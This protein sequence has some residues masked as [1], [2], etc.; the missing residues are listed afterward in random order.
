MLHQ[1]LRTAIRGLRHRPGAAVAAL[2]TLTLGIGATT[3][4][5]GVVDH[6]LLRPLA[7]GDAGDLY[8]V[9]GVTAS[10][11]RIQPSH[12]D[13]LDWREV[14]TSLELAFVHGDVFAVRG[15]EGVEQVTGSAVSPDFFGVMRT[16]AALGRTFAPDEEREGAPVVVLSHGY[17]H[18]RFGGDRAAISGDVAIDG[19]PHTVVGVMPAGFE[20][21][22]WSQLW[23]PLA[24]L[25]GAVPGLRQ[26]DA[27]VDSRAIARPAG[28]HPEVAEIGRAHV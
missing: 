6:V 10:F 21:P 22:E 8:S 12:P 24:R 5:L 4:L 18:R 14:T 9:W 17:W 2:L 1:D 26:R 23:V 25:H 11:D 16:Q 28:V 15:G 7:Y 19:V 27:R 20:Y 13:F 3:A